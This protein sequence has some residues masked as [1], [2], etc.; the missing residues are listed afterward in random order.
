MGP[1]MGIMVRLK[2]WIF[3]SLA[4]LAFDINYANSKTS[5]IIELLAAASATEAITQ[6][7][8]SVKQDL[9]IRLRPTFAGS[10]TLAKHIAAGAQAHLFLSAD[11][12]WMSY[13]E[14]RKLVNKVHRV[15]LLSNKLV[16]LQRNGTKPKTTLINFVSALSNERLVMGDPTHVP[17]GRYGKQALE[18]L[19]L[20][21]SVKSR[22]VFGAS[23]RNALALF[24]RGYGS[25]AIAYSTD[26]RVYPALNIAFRFPADSHAPIIYPLALVNTEINVRAQKVFDYLQNENSRSVFTNYG[27]TFLPR[28]R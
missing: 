10:S 20:W 17:A 2:R 22:A 7:A 11:P 26:T 25:L 28:P 18:S 9:N 6:I 1:V 21:Q 23:I 15:D 27:F 5:D 24:S 14:K 4:I 3:I 19:G 8:L 12:E 16:L 13:L